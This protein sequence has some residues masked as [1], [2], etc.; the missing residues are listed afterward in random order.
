M[1]Y[2]IDLTAITLED[3]REKLRTADLLPSRMILKDDIDR[4]FAVFQSLGLSNVEDLRKALNGKKKLQDFASES[5]LSED[6]LT[7]LIRE[8][9]SLQPKPNKLSD[10]PGTPLEAVERLAETGIKHTAHLY[11]YVQTPT[12]RASLAARTGV[13]E[14]EILRLARLTDLS[15]IRWVN[16][17]FAFVLLEAGY[18]CAAQVAGADPAQ[19]YEDVKRL[20]DRRKIYNA[21]IGLH[22]MV[23]C[24]AAAKEVPRDMVF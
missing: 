16:H 17:T 20:N 9:R 23:L 24:V 3:Y 7:I 4:I 11:E 18:G 14:G 12:D 21:H 13:D 10:F 2:H 5:G 19:V 22:D 8:I 1:S 6:Y 15:R